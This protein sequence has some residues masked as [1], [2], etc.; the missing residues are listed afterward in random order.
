MPQREIAFATG[1]VFVLH[2]DGVY[3]TADSAGEQYGMERL[4]RLV[5]S[6]EG[7]IAEIRD[8]IL[9]EMARF[10]GNRPQEDDVTVVVV[11]IG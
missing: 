3:E 6:L 2:S 1:D 8:D 7:S 4:L 10:R 11:K 9:H 5:A